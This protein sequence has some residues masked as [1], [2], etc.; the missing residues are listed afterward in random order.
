MKDFVKNCPQAWTDFFCFIWLGNFMMKFKICIE[1]ESNGRTC[2]LLNMLNCCLRKMSQKYK[3]L[4]QGI[5]Y[6]YLLPMR[7]I[8]RLAI[9]KKSENRYVFYYTVC[10]AEFDAGKH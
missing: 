9:I 8:K 6:T 4:P 3:R 10:N 1:K 2:L 7:T 5:S